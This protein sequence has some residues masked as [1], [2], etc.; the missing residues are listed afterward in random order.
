MQMLLKSEEPVAFR[1]TSSVDFTYEIFDDEKNVY[2][3]GQIFP[4]TVL[5][6]FRVK[7]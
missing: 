3:F 4:E 5:L 2:Y 6:K 7:K 1:D